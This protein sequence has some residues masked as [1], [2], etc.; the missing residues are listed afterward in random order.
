MSVIIKNRRCEERSLE[1]WEVVVEERDNFSFEIEKFGHLLY[2][3]FFLFLFWHGQ[4][5]VESTFRVLLCACLETFPF[6][7]IQARDDV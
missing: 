2:T 1:N 4:F 5:F 6:Y 7:Q 3:F